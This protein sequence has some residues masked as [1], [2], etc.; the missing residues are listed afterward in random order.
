VSTTKSRGFI[1][2]GS[3]DGT[4]TGGP[5]YCI[6]DETNKNRKAIRGALIMARKHTEPDTAGSQFIIG[7]DNLAYLDGTYTVFG[8]VVEGGEVL[9]RLLEGTVIRRAIVKRKRD[10]EYTPAKILTVGEK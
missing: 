9:D 5:E 7:L 10:H 8:H 6:A 2:G 4:S 3:P 1:Q